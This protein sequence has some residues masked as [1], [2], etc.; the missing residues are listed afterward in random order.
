MTPPA[1]GAQ[2]RAISLLTSRG[3]TALTSG[4]PKIQNRAGWPVRDRC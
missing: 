1:A 4:G 2:Q 3:T